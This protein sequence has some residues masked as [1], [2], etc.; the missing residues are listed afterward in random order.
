MVKVWGK[1]NDWSTVSKA[2]I[3]LNLFIAA[4]D[5]CIEKAGLVAELGTM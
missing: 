4:I 1:I 3:F 5:C 2:A